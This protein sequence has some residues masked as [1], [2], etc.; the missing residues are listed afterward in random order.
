M[1]SIHS[2]AC[3]EFRRRPGSLIDRGFSLDA[4]RMLDWADRSDANYGEK[5]QMAEGMLQSLK[6]QPSTTLRWLHN[7][8]FD[9]LIEL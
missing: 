7:R 6:E 2:L 5:S 1:A 3:A 8:E 4:L 9:R